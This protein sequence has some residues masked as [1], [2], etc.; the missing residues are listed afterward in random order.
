MSAN[1]KYYQD[2]LAKLEKGDY[3]TTIKIVDGNRNAT[4][5]INLN[6]ESIDVL[7]EYLNSLKGKTFETMK[8]KK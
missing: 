3:P 6:N 7:I 4:N 5:C 8:L 2:Q 1:K